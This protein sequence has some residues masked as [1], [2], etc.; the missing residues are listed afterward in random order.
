MKRQFEALR[1]G[2]RFFFSHR[3]TG[4]RPQGLHPVA[5]ENIRGRSLGAV[6]CDNL[7]AS[8]RESVL[9]PRT[10]GQ[11]IF[12]TPDS[13]TNPELDCRK[14]KQGSGFLDLQMIFNET[15]SLPGLSSVL[16]KALKDEELKD[17]DD[18]EEGF[19]KSVNFPQHYLDSFDEETKLQVDKGNVIE[20]TIHEF[21]LEDD[22]S[23]DSS[24]CRFDFV[25]IF[26]SNGKG[27]Y[28]K[29][30]G[31]N[32]AVGTKFRSKGNEMTVRFHS[33]RAGNH[34]GF[35]AA[36]KEVQTHYKNPRLVQS[37][38][39]TYSNFWN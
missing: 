15:V 19:V 35:K 5:K 39:T 30:C 20:L 22:P 9:F 8:V 7:D 31:N 1:D 28:A 32:V 13:K 4:L 3:R 21:D 25:E 38:T 33:D 24:P 14:L 27:T 2:D 23:Q 34:K 12:R 18:V 10:V 26:E 17:Q 6:Y 36:W 29:M 11:N 16:K 37:T